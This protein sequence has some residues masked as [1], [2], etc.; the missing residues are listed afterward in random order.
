MVRNT[1]RQ[2]SGYNNTSQW[3]IVSL[4]LEQSPEKTIGGVLRGVEASVGDTA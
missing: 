4:A 3:L 2:L 1:Q